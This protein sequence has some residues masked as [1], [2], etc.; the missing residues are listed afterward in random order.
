MIVYGGR[1]GRVG[2]FRVVLEGKIVRVEL[3]IEGLGNFCIVVDIWFWVRGC[4]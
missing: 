3:F 1:I 4:T 2:G